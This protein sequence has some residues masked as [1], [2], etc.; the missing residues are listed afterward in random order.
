MNRAVVLTSGGM[1]SCVCVA[2][3]ALDY[4]IALLHAS[5]GQRTAEQ[6]LTAFHAIGDHFQVGERLVLDL[7][8]LAAMGG[9]ALTD[10]SLE[11][12]KFDASSVGQRI[13]AS[14]VPF[15]NGN[16][17]AAAV[18]WAEVLGAQAIY[19]G[20]VAAD[21]SGYP[22]CRPEFLDAFARAAELGTR[23][24]TR[25]SIK[26]PLVN[27]TKAQIIRLGIQHQA[28]LG[29]TWS[30]YQSGPKACGT[31]ESCGLRLR[32]FTQAGVADPIEY[33]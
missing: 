9:S 6:E 13:P 19:I 31:C 28:P 1:D 26:A 18:S 11:L 17:L 25:I 14:Y 29:L 12:E 22:D 16:L 2:L 5:Y 27:L 8:H 21:S 20:A 32:A 33:R 23:P 30:C 10:A 4:E 3:A 7:S 15:R 24:E